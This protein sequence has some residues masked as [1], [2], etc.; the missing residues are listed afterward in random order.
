MSLQHW[1]FSKENA[2]PKMMKL[3]SIRVKLKQKCIIPTKFIW[4]WRCFCHGRWQQQFYDKRNC[5]SGRKSQ[6]RIVLYD[7]DCWNSNAKQN[8]NFTK[9]CVYFF[10][11][12]IF[13]FFPCL[14]Q[15]TSNFFGLQPSICKSLMPVFP[16]IAGLWNM[17]R[18]QKT[19][20]IN[21]LRQDQRYVISA[22]QPTK[23]NRRIKSFF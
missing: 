15:V 1:S 17:K 3:P 4:K 20:L 8:W 10:Q 9:K 11:L 23:I 22:H 16:F 5:K 19:K 13:N 7:R 14:K 2:S 6:F 12:F 18:L 21:A